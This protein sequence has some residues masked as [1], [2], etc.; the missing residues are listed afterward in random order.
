MSEGCDSVMIDRKDNEME[1]YEC[2]R[3]GAWVQPNEEHAEIG[4]DF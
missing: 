2:A 3:C 4:C 1:E